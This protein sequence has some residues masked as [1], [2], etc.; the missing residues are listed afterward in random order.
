MSSSTDFS[1]AG[2]RLGIDAQL[3]TFP[4]HGQDELRSPPVARPTVRDRPHSRLFWD[5]LLLLELY[6]SGPRSPRDRL[7]GERDSHRPRL[8]DNQRALAAAPAAVPS[9]QTN[10]SWS[11]IALSRSRLPKIR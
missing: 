3:T 2:A 6:G 5:L 10:K 7:S 11:A 9:I 1:P 8:R 4:H